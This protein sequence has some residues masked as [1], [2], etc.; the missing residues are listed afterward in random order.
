MIARAADL[1]E[2]Y[3]AIEILERNLAED[4][5]RLALL[6]ADRDMTFGEVAEEV[7]RVG[8][9]LRDLGVHAGDAVAILSLDTAEWAVSFFACLKIGAVAVGMNTM[10]TVREQAYILRDAGARVLLVHASLLETARGALASAPNVAQV[11]VI[12]SQGALDDDLGKPARAYEA[13]IADASTE[14]VAADTHRSD[15]GTLNYSSGTTGKPKGIYHSHQD[16]AL[17]AQ[18]WGMNVLGLRADDRT[19]AVAKLFFTFGL[20]GNLVFPWFAG[21]AVVLYAGSPRIAADVLRVIDRFKPTIL[22][23]SPTSYASILAVDDFTE[24]Y[25]LTSLRVGVSAGEALPAPLWHEFHDR[26]GVELIDGIGS[27]ENFHIF[28]SN[29]PGEVRPGSSGKPVPGYECRIMDADG[30]ATPTGEIGNLHLKGETAAL[31]YLHD[32]QRSRETFRGE[33]LDT[34]DKYFV[35]EDGYFWHAGR[36]DDMLKVGGIWVSPVEVESTLISH[37]AVLE[38]AVVGITDASDLVK[39]K[40]YVVLKDGFVGDDTLSDELVGYCRTNMAA[41]KRPRWIEFVEDLPKT[42]TGKIQRYRLRSAGD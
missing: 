3:N 34:G 4:A 41:Y 21:A 29:T 39:P 11:V 13:W 35:D 8:N 20:G 27:T 24:N 7:D 5:D 1:P 23:T 16:Y 37:E 19:F 25:D 30:R 14:L 18:L 36:T 38:C 6:S 31:F 15:F 12:G 42:A 10:L 17:T 40:A 26:T 2:R 32:P 22:L 28:V 33:W 9:G